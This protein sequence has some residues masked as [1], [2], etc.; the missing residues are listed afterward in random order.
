MSNSR[1]R[2]HSSPLHALGAVSD[3]RGVHFAVFSE[4]AEKIELC[5]FDHAGRPERAR[6]D[7]P[8]CTNGI[9]HGYLPGAQ[10]G[11]QYGYRAHGP[12][13]PK[14]GLRFNPHKLLLDPYTR[15]LTGELRWHDALYGYRIGSPRGDLSFDRRDSAMYMPKSVVVTDNFPWEDDRPPRTPWSDTIIYE[16]HVGGFTRLRNDLPAHDRG[17]FGA[18]G[19]RTTIDYLLRLGIT[20]VELLPIH[21]FA[22]DR[23][24]LD[25]QLDNYWGYNTLAYFAPHPAYLSDGTLGQIKWAIQ[26]LHRVGIEVILD[27]VYNHTCEGSE[28]GPTLS[29]RGLDNLNY[30]RLLLDDPRYYIN[31]TGCGNTVNFSQQRVIQ[32]TMDSLRYWVQEFHVDGFRFDLGV[33]L[34][35]EAGGFDPGSGFFDALLQDPILARVKLIS[36]P[37]DIGPGGFQIG[38][39]PPGF[40]EWNGLFR[41][42]VRRY[43]RGDDAQRGGFAQRLQGSAELFDRQRRHP[44]ASINFVTAHDGFTLN[45][46]V[47]YND[48]HNE[49]NGEENHDGAD[50]NYSYNWG[51]EGAT[52]TP[53]VNEQRDKIMRNFFATLLIAH[54]TPM[55]LAGDEFGQTQQG[56]NNAYCHNDNLSWL[57]WNLLAQKRGADLRDFVARVIALRKQ[58]PLL[59]D[60]YFWQGETQITGD[61]TAIYW[62]D[63]RGVELQLADWNNG[64]AHLLGLRRAYIDANDR[65]EVQLLLTNSDT[66]AHTFTLPAPHLNFRIAIDTDDPSITEAPLPAQSYDVAAHS[67]V[68]LRALTDRQTLINIAADQQQP[69]EVGADT[70]D[71]EASAIMGDE[72]PA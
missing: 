16:M 48:K 60:P 11:Q 64:A 1:N 69:I 40:G 21:A 59:R 66:Y 4:H 28:L 14:N 22:R 26:Q 45:D 29:M 15:K 18:L 33:T 3:G 44:W 54:G 67:L 42:D 23:H 38:N 65:V 31:D 58:S 34:G 47:S 6:F 20:A 63:E 53:I 72:V 30:Y 32:L 27:V 12:Y 70:V 62:F 36:E 35:R 10:A 17:T 8:D 13:E 57:D 55:L 7:M 37:W 5:L 43:W 25:K 68:L 50:D 49:T 9:W 41:D 39:H 56:N 19:H 61:L 24:L 71:V 52:D 46:L 2:L 51:S